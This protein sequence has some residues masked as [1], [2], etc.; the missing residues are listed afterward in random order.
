[1]QE[2]DPADAKSSLILVPIDVND[3]IDVSSGRSPVVRFA[4]AP[5]PMA[6]QEATSRLISDL[7][8]AGELTQLL[9]CIRGGPDIGLFEVNKAADRIAGACHPEVKASFG[10]ALDTTFK[11]ERQ[12]AVLASVPH[13][14]DLPLPSSNPSRPT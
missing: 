14:S 10:V 2:N 5:G 6:M 9:I 13:L 4:E 11:G 8:N 3:V 7:P 1:M 12:I